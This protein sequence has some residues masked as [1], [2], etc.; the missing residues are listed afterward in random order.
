[1]ALKKSDPAAGNKADE[2]FSKTNERLEVPEGEIPEGKEKMKTVSFQMRPTDYKKLK[3][4][5]STLGL[6][7]GSGLRFALTEFLRK[8][9]KE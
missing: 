7:P 3:D 1:M 9:K 2:V 8:Y 5:F 4:I 6:S